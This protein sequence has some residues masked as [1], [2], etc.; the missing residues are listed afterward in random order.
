[1][2]L[3]YK[4]RLELDPG[5]KDIK[6]WMT[7]DLSSLPEAV[8][9]LA[10]K[11]YLI[12]KMFLDDQK[13][14]DV[15]K[16]YNT[17]PSSVIRILNRVFSG[18]HNQPPALTKGLIPH[19]RLRKSIR[20]SE[21]SEFG[22]DLGAQC[23]FEALLR[24]LPGLDDYLR[25]VVKAYVN[26][27]RYGEN[28][29]I[30][31]FHGLFLRYLSDHNW[32]RDK[33]PFDQKKQGFESL[34]KY[35]HY[36]VA[37]ASIPKSN[38][39][40]YLSRFPIKHAYS[41]IQIDS[42]TLDIHVSAYFDFNG[43]I[44]PQRLSRVTLF[45]AI[46]VATDC[47]LAYKVCYT[48]SPTLNDLLDLLGLINMKWQPRKL[49]TPG[50]AY[51][52]GACL[53]S[54]L[55]RSHQCAGIGIVSMDNAK[56]H[57]SKT[58]HDY[59]CNEMGAC[60]KY[61]LPAHPK[62]RH[63]VEYAFKRLNEH[64]HRFSCTTGSSPVDPKRESMQNAKKPPVISI[65]ALEDILSVVLT[66]HNTQPQNRLLG[67]SPLSMIEY[68]MSNC[69]LRINHHI[70]QNQPNPHFREKRVKV[71][72]SVKE[73]RIPYVHF[74]GL[75]YSAPNVLDHTT[76]NKQIIVK[77]NSKDIRQLEAFTL[78]GERLGTLNA[79]KSWQLYEHG[80]DS[81]KFI[82]G[83]VR[84]KKISG[85][86]PLHGALAYLYKHKE[87]PKEALSLTRLYLEFSAPEK[88][89]VPV[90]DESFKPKQSIVRINKKII[91]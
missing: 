78:N 21:L 57:H 66:H 45:I 26:K 49:T 90:N 56:C 40:K 44:T 48:E 24:M 29:T 35:Y 12:V 89:R 4:K 70:V 53:P 13:I 2:Y 36:L 10:I 46:D 5:L 43:M 39:A 88:D 52:P 82:L 59:V 80:I 19:A 67:H 83:L 60:L 38:T 79:P 65:Q 7:I 42:Q 73:K 47:I 76:I 64:I 30:K 62:T 77:F 33:Y 17:S 11:Y 37:E 86:D 23:S 63:V 91:K 34:R 72:W 22:N 54:S 55:S 25:K 58:I 16:E 74:E 41:E 68:Q 85:H 8:R 61:G 51:T 75:R 31:S 71:C 3:N 9:D 69:L 84:D 50:L 15:A 14:K 6:S 32:P 20:R 87:L 81:R 1:M 28:L 27:R 18:E